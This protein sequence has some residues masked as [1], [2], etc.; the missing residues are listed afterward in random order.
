MATVSR[1]GRITRQSAL[2]LILLLILLPLKGSAAALFSAEQAYRAAREAADDNDLRRALEMVELA[3]ERVCDRGDDPAV[4]SLRILREEIIFRL[5]GKGS[6]AALKALEAELPPRFRTSEAAVRRLLALGMGVAAADHK[7]AV[8][9]LRQAHALA[10]AHQPQLLSQTHLALGNVAEFNEAEAHLRAA[11]ELAQRKHSAPDLAK[12]K[13]A[14]G[15]RYTQERR[16]ADSV[17]AGEESLAAWKTVVPPAIKRLPTATGNLGWAYLELGEH[18]RAEELFQQAIDVAT[19]ARLDGE[20]VTWTNALGQVFFA[21]RQFASAEKAFREALVFGRQTNY[22]RL[23]DILSN[24][25]R[26]ALETGRYREAQ[27]WNSEAVAARGGATTSNRI[28]Q[29]RI[30]TMTGKYGAAKDALLAVLVAADKAKKPEWEAE[31]RLAQLYVTMSRADDADATFQHAI[32]TFRIAREGVRSSELR[33]SFFNTAE[34]LFDTYIEFLTHARRTEDALYATEQI[35]AQTLVEAGD[36]APRYI[37]PRT[38]ARQRGLT[39]LSY[40]L[41]RRHSYVWTVTSSSIALVKLPAEE[42][43]N[44]LADR[45]R[46]DLLG[47]N[48]TIELSGQRGGDLYRML[49]VPALHGASPD[50]PIAIVADGRLHALNFETL[51]TGDPPHYW[52]EDVI[53]SS[54]SSVQILARAEAEPLRKA[55]MLLVGDALPVSGYPALQHAAEEI[56]NVTRHFPD[57]KTLTREDATPTGYRAADPGRYAYIHFVAHGVASGLRPLDSAIILSPDAGGYKL[58]ARDIMAQPLTA[59]LVTISSCQ[60]AGERTYAGEGLVGLAWAFLHAGAS[61]VI[62]AVLDVNDAVTPTLMDDFYAGIQ[63]GHSPATA[64]RDA[65][66]KFVHKD[67]VYRRPKYW[68]PLVLYSGS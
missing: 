22:D 28:L 56:A 50:T 44:L 60:G 3:L 57:A 29:A 53:L 54:A 38:I 31:A 20:R 45:Y 37:D 62:A 5:G 34:D 64:L 15:R 27:R 52:I 58:I 48:G 61:E 18:E 42:T 11:I 46:A 4:W 55:D 26:T 67:S 17:Q 47:P 32:N 63:S 25:S 43:I 10:T 21:E 16:L 40:W 36:L 41:G 19:R 12:A 1:S 6:Q 7:R 30:D 59:R 14:L 8:L 33:L 13:T 35:R 66:L 9:Y 65:K 51:V 23:G 2:L 24:L 49:V 68:A 39:I